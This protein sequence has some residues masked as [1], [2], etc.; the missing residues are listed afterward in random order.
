MRVFCPEHKR[1]FLA[2]R[3]SP[4]KCDNRGHLLG[5]LDFEGEAKPPAELQ[6]QYCCNCEHFCP[7]DF[8]EYGLERCSVCN[9]RSSVV[10]LCN[11]CYTISFESDTPVATK[12]FTLNSEGA[13]KPFCP[14]CLQPTSADLREHVCEAG[15]GGSFF[16]ALNSCP[17]CQERLD[18]GPSFPSSL[19]HYLRRTKAANKLNVT[20]DY[21][22]ELFVPVEDGEF[23]LISNG[24]QAAQPVVL[25]R[26]VRFENKRIFYEFYQDYYHCAKPDVGEVH[27][28]EPAAVTAVADGWKFEATGVLEVLIDQPKKTAPIAVTPH[29]A[30]SSIREEARD[31]AA[32]KEPVSPCSH[33]GSPIETRYTFC[34]KCGHPMRAQDQSGVG[35][36]ETV[37]HSVSLAALAADDDEQTV[38]H[39]LRPA[40]SQMF[41][42]ALAKTSERPKLTNMSVL[43]L[44]V[45][46]AIGLILG[47]LGL[48][49]LTWSPASTAAVT[50]AEAI[51]SNAQPQASIASAGEERLAEATDAKPQQ[52]TSPAGDNDEL[53]QLRERRIDG[54]ASNRSE[55]L[56]TLVSAERKYPDDYRFPYERAKLAVKAREATSHNEAFAALSRAA[57]KAISA[58]KAREMLDSLEADKAGDFRKLAHG[59]REWTQ[60]QEALKSK[61]VRGLNARMG[62]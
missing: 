15:S 19:A 50:D 34:W 26:S 44:V 48:V 52:R 30:E 14:G 3:Q 20:F 45:A 35:Q 21:E 29:R 13:P 49:M 28:I 41:S 12:N 40:S 46:S 6:W 55:I 42:W 24:E 16:T 53:K 61:D 56:K 39:E 51:T 57:Q 32:T 23:V 18:I 11:R 22:S 58:G 59:H 31:I 17:I 7:I 25:P 1:G 33:C 10:Y 54:N 27:I 47:S 9:R 43:K 37:P 5:H 38:Q 62:L 8:D 2:P 36:S 4:I 60:L